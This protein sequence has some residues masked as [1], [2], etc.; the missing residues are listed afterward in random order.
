MA[1]VL[2]ALYDD[3][4]NGYPKSYPWDG[5]PKIDRYHRRSIG[6]NAEAH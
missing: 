3:P 1:K 4:V 5:V 6:A 2:C